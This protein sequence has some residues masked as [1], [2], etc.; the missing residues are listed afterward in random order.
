MLKFIAM[1]GK[2]WSFIKPIFSDLMQIIKEV[3][4][5]DLTGDAARKKV[6]QDITDFIQERGLEKIP[7]SVLNAGIELCYQLYVWKKA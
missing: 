5:S 6:T 3:K 2:V 4:E 7:D 1:A